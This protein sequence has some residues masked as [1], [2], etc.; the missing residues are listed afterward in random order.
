[1]LKSKICDLRQYFYVIKAILV[2]SVHFVTDTIHWGNTGLSP[3]NAGLTTGDSIT[4]SGAS[5]HGI[6]GSLGTRSGG[7]SASLP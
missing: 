6:W 7:E 2:V 1:V 3:K 4:Y 5:I